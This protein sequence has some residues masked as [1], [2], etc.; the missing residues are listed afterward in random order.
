MATYN[1]I[2]DNKNWPEA[3]WRAISRICSVSTWHYGYRVDSSS[4]VRMLV[5]TRLYILLDTKAHTKTSVLTRIVTHW[6]LSCESS[7]RRI[8]NIFFILFSFFPSL[9][10]ALYQIF[11]YLCCL[12]NE[13]NFYHNYVFIDAMIKNVIW[14]SHI[15]N[16]HSRL[17]CL[18]I[19]DLICIIQIYLYFNYFK[20]AII[21]FFFLEK[22]TSNNSEKLLRIFLNLNKI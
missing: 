13:Q 1:T 10:L 20:K 8:I 3:V 4:S 7:M 19:H 18:Y 15:V 6:C 22:K 5:Y 16:Q 14:G 17:S 12:S 9:S 21:F 11:L 2:V